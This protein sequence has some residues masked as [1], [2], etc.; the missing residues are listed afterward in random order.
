[1][2]EDLDRAETQEEREKIKRAIEEVAEQI[3]RMDD[4]D[5]AI[6]AVDIFK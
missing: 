1:L 6:K 2:S 5:G 3:S 4:E